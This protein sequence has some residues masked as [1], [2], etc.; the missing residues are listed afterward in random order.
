[1]SNVR[2]DPVTALW[3]SIF[4]RNKMGL[5]LH[6]PNVWD[7]GFINDLFEAGNVK[8]VIDK[9]YPLSEVAEAM[10]YFGDGYAKRNVLI[11]MEEN[12]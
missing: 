2:P 7:L 8:P 4:N 11:T 1:M 6:K 12:L 5:L 9:C 10:R 3:V